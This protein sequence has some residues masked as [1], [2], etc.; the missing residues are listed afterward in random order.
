MNWKEHHDTAK[1]D[2]ASYWSTEAKKL[3]WYRQPDETLT[4]HENGTWSWFTG[5]MM[6]TCFLALDRHVEF[7]RG[8]ETALIYDSPV[9][10][11]KKKYT[12]RSRTSRTASRR[13]ESERED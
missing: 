4:T 3:H 2:P 7:G 13:W 11:T 6:N 12:F 8:D 10:Q 9:T 1:A 5:G